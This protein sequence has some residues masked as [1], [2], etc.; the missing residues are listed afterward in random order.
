[1]KNSKCVHFLQWSLPQLHLRWS[2]FRKVRRQVCKRIQRRLQELELCDISAYQSYL[3]TYPAE[4]LVLDAYCRI[5]I[6][7]F[8]RDQMEKV[9]IFWESDRI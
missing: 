3:E 7:R 9:A 2:G 5:T 1:M 4:W 6:S 8:Y